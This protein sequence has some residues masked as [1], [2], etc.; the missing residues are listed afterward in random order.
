MYFEFLTNSRRPSPLSA[1]PEQHL[2][3][4]QMNTEYNL[5]LS[6]YD[7]EDGLKKTLKNTSELPKELRRQIDLIPLTYTQPTHIN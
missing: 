6:Y 4:S 3:E 7:I 2:D 5:D 1:T